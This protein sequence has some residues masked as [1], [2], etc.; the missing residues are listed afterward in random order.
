MAKGRQGGHVG[1]PTRG[2]GSNTFRCPVA[3]SALGRY[4]HSLL[5][6]GQR[7]APG[8][9][10]EIYVAGRLVDVDSLDN[11]GHQALPIEREQLI[12]DSIEVL[13]LL[14]DPTRLE[15]D[16]GRARQAATPTHE[17]WR[18]RRRARS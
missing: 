7:G 9:K 18:A 17:V 3:A 11:G 8:L 16:G 1:R 12:P 4:P 6:T 10:D 2:L 14:T 5:T 13:E 15:D